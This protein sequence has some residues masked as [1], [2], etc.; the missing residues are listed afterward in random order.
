VYEDP[1]RPR[2]RPFFLVQ[3]AISRTREIGRLRCR[4][5][6]VRRPSS[7]RPGMVCPSRGG[8][9]MPKLE[10]SPT[11]IMLAEPCRPNVISGETVA[12]ML[13]VIQSPAIVVQRL[14]RPICFF[15]L[16]PS[17]PRTRDA[18]LQRLAQTRYAAEDLRACESFEGAESS[19]CFLRAGGPVGGV[20]PVVSQRS[21][22]HS[23]GRVGERGDS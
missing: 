17:K 22:A 13:H 1:W 21:P 23:R 5:S 12:H 3:M 2:G 15:R 8:S 7:A 11:R 16:H 4:Q 19:S 14:F 18:E 20:P 9:S 10:S 6:P